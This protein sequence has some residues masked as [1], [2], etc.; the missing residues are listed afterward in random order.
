MDL[1]IEQVGTDRLA[2]YARIPIAF[3]VTHHLSV[4]P[5]EGGLGGFRLREERVECP[6]VKDYDDSEEGGP[7]RWVEHFD[8]TNFAVFLATEGGRNIGGATVAFDTPDLH[9][10]AGRRDLAVLWDIR[11]LPGRRR[12]KIGTR[13][14]KHAA[15]W[16]GS[17]GC[18]MLK[19]E[20]QNINLP[21]CRF[22]LK[23]G[24][25]LGEINRYAY[26]ATP[27][28]AHEVMLVWYLDLDSIF[29]L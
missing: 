18:R 22:Y 2:D 23:Q 12:A 5:T 16:A 10:L 19:I 1:K 25:H 11:V 7:D 17:K 9:I 8:L 6:Y 15:G 13:L 26:A 21:A 20:T 28:V 27:S 3:E 24:C 4:E 29:E 14:F